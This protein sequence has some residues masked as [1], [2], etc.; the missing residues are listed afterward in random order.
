MEVIVHSDRFR[1]HRVPKGDIFNELHWKLDKQK[2][3]SEVSALVCALSSEFHNLYHDKYLELY[4]DCDI[5]IHESP[6]MLRYDLFFDIDD[7][8]RIYNSYN[9]ESDLMSQMWS[10]EYA[11]G[12]ISLV[13]ELEGE[14]VRK[15][16]LVFATCE[17]DKR[18][19]IKEFDVNEEKVKLAPNG[20]N[21]EEYTMRDNHTEA[22]DNTALFIGSAHPPNIETV[23]FIVNHVAGKCKNITFQIAGSCSDKAKVESRQNVKLLGFVAQE[24]KER[25]FRNCKIAINPMFSGSGTN[26]KTLEFFSAG[27]PVLSTETGVRGLSVVDGEHYYLA[28]EDNF[29]KRLCELLDKPEDMNKVAATGRTHVNSTYSW[30]KIAEIAHNEIDNLPQK[31]H[32]PTLLIL[33]DFSAAVPKG[34]GEVRINNLYRHMSQRYKVLHL[35]LNGD[36][37]ILRTIPAPQFIEISIPKTKEHIAE[38]ERMDSYHPASAA[39]IVSSYM[40]KH[41]RLL[42]TML[43][44]SITFADTVILVHPYMS[45]LID[46][47]TDI[48]IIYESLN[49]ESKLKREL[50]Q[51]HPEYD[52]LCNKAEKAEGRAIDLANFIITCSK[53][54]M[55]PEADKPVFVIENGV[56]IQMG[57][58]HPNSEK[59]KAKFNKHPIVVFIGS[60]HTPNVEA[61]EY[62]IAS[63]AK[64]MPHIYFML[65]GGVCDSFDKSPL[66]DN[67]IPMGR[68]GVSDKNTLMGLADIA[69]NPMRNGF[70]SNLKLADYFASRIPVITSPLGMRGYSITHKEHALVCELDGFGKAVS[71]LLIDTA[72]QK[73]ITGNAYN[74]V[75]NNL[76]W[77]ILAKKYS[78][79]VEK[80]VLSNSTH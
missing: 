16:D 30:A 41:N 27:V 55:Y 44:K 53:D 71:S 13:R 33:N 76:R 67:V 57:K 5:I 35:C 73:S 23:E 29:A 34:G 9:Y 12:Y 15:C 25:L 43:K 48:P 32:T 31:T 22:S 3:C 24:E 19:F 60:G 18:K 21:P 26:L 46:A 8:P 38:Q 47:D 14:L 62:I 1:E 54:E 65:I 51:G 20:I 39:D 68:V 28:D 74:Y 17:D 75:H 11:V 4:S 50:L 40:C 42:A 45:E 52:F 6:Y 37:S 59:L 2:I 49:Y 70:G 64:E 61:A 58:K 78:N 66:P 36:N 56:E 7:K 69:L 77:Q 72:L 80:Q 10:G 79:L 63:L